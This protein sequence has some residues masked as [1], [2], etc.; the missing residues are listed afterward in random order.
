MKSEKVIVKIG[1]KNV[2][3]ITLNRPENLNTFNSILAEQLYD[4]LL[5]L[6]ADKNVRVVLLNGAGNFDNILFVAASQ[7]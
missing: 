6:D 5:K 1:Q 2:A 7:N 4:A 3:E